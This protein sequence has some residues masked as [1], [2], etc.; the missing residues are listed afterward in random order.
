[1]T[2]IFLE[3]GRILINE[4]KNNK[5]NMSGILITSFK[6]KCMASEIIDRLYKQI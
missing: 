1:M 4:F 2:Y 6:E 3:L 5:K